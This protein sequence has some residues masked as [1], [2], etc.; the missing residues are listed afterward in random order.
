M[1]SLLVRSMLAN[2]TL[3]N[4]MLT[5]R[6]CPKN[7]GGGIAPAANRAL[8]EGAPRSVNVFCCCRVG[9]AGPQGGGK[10]LMRLNFLH[11][12]GNGWRRLRGLT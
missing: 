2:S 4:S 7:S 6:R 11:P 3:A 10:L 1:L 9:R 12:P 5:C 8:I